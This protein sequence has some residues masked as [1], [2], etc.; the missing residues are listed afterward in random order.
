MNCR[1]KGNDMKRGTGWLFTAVIGVIAVLGIIGLAGSN[2]IVGMENA[3]EEKRNMKEQRVET[4]TSHMVSFAEAKIET[5]MLTKRINERN[6]F[7]LDD[8][9][10]WEQEDFDY[11]YYADLTLEDTE[12]LQGHV[13]GQWR[14]S[15]RLFPTGRG[16]KYNFTGQG[17]EEMKDIIVSIG[18]DSVGGISGLHQETFTN[19]QDISLFAEY[20]GFSTTNLP[21]YRVMGNVNPYKVPLIHDFGTVNFGEKEELIMVRYGLGYYS[22]NNYYPGVDEYNGFGIEEFGNIIYIDPND[23]DTLYMCFCG[24]WELKRDHGTYEDGSETALLPGRDDEK[25]E[26]DLTEKDMEFLKEHLFGQWAFSRRLVALDEGLNKYQGTVSNFSA[27]GVEELKEM[28]FTYGEG[29]VRPLLLRR[30]LSNPTDMYLFGIYGGLNLVYLPYYHI[31][32]EVDEGNI[33]L[34]DLYGE[35]TYS[36]E[37]PEDKELVRVYYNWGYDETA[38]PSVSMI[39]MGSNIYIDPEDTETIYVD[40]GG[41]WEMKRDNDYYGTN[42][43]HSGKG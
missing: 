3:E 2:F 42:G 14:F 20:G 23:P 39:Y 26:Y 34:T 6:R 18:P 8:V 29:D 35:G 41:L 32:T 13:F 33:L 43:K 40:F 4:M 30:F 28:R 7:E 37:F 21:V 22:I 9:P 12:F 15:K 25:W 19:P 27:Q 5:A 31:D 38:Y 24:L 10:K 17:M 16:D 1:G 36:V 11:K